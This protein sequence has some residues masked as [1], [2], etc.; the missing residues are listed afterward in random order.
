[1]SAHAGKPRVRPLAETLSAFADRLFRTGGRDPGD[2][3][4]PVP[5]ERLEIYRSLLVGGA[6]SMLSFACT[7][8]LRLTDR[9]GFARDDLIRRFLAASPPASHSTREIA[10]RFAAFVHAHCPDVLARR[11]DVADLLLLERAELRAAYHADD[12]GRGAAPDDIAGL[13]ASS[14][15]ALLS[16]R[17]V[18]A[19]SG[20]VLRFDRPVLD[21]RAALLRREHPPCP[22]AGDQWVV[23]GRGPV[24]LE[25]TLAPVSPRGASALTAAAPGEPVTIEGLAE[26]W[27][28]ELDAADTSV[29]EDTLF[30]EFAEAVFAALACGFLRLADPR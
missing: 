17:V 30:R 6:R 9:E 12:P 10:D 7:A 8:T 11:P 25:P 23:V 19:P 29:G 26:R 15:D 22:P 2:D 3:A 1:M 16:T 21:V 27:L 28:G 5:A 20:S 18:R 14:V 24:D 13:R 4:V